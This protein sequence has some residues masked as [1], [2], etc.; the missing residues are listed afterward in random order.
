MKD[1][2]KKYRRRQNATIQKTD[3]E[4]LRFRNIERP[5][6][7]C[8]DRMGIITIENLQGAID[9]NGI[10]KLID[11]MSDSGY[12]PSKHEKWRLMGAV[13]GKNWKVMLKEMRGK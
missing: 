10:D 9:K 7:E 12:T 2:F 4:P 13:R 8:L 1:R 3:E 6:Q 5:T 11:Q